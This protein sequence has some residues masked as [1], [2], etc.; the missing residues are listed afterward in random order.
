MKYPMT[1][2]C[3]AA[4][5]LAFVL[6]QGPALIAADVF[7][8]G[9]AKL[10]VYTNI[11][12]VLVDDLRN[13]PNGNYPGSPGE[14][15]YLAGL[16]SPSNYG[17]NYGARVS[18]FITPPATGSYVF[19]ISSD[20]AGEFWL[21]TDE[22]PN[23]LELLAMEPQWNGVREWGLP[24]SNTASRNPDAPENVSAPRQLTEG[25]RYYFEALVKEG[26]GGD[27]L[28]VAV[29]GANDPVPQNGSAPVSGTW[30]GVVV[31]D[32]GASVQIAQQPTGVSSA[33]NENVTFT[34]GATGTS[35]LGTNLVY[36]WFRNGDPI[37]GATSATL[38]LNRVQTADNGAAYSVLVAVPGAQATSSE[39]TLTV[40]PDV[41]PPT[42]AAAR[43]TVNFN[44][45]FVTFSEPVAQASATT[46]AN[47]TLNGGATV[48]SAT[49]VDPTTVRLVTSQL[50]EAT[51]YTL[52]VNNVTD[53]FT[54]GNP[55]AANSTVN[56]SSYTFL[57]G[58]VLN[59]FWDGP[60]SVN[61]LTNLAAFPDDPD[62]VALQ[63][64]FEYP[65]EGGGEG[66]SNYGN[67][68][69]AWWTAPES[70]NYVFFVSG[71]DTVN[72][73]LSTDSDPANV[74]LI[75]AEPTWNPARDWL[76]TL[77]PG[78][79][80][81]RPNGE[82][83]SDTFLES[84][85]PTPNVITLE[86]GQRYYLLALHGEGGG[87]DNVGATYVLQ[88]DP[89]PESGTPPIPGSELGFYYDASLST[90]EVT[91][92]PSAQTVLEGR[93]ATVSAGATG[94]W[95]WSDQ[96]FY[97]WQSAA[98]GGTAFTNIPGATGS[99]VT[100]PVLQQ[101]ESGVQ[102][103]VL[104]SVPGFNVTS[105]VAAVTVQADQVA[106]AINSVAANSS[107]ALSV[108][109][110]EPLDPAT[111]ATVAN[112]TLTPGG[113]TIT[114]ATLGGAMSNVVL[115]ATSAAIT[116]GNQYT[117][118]VSGVRDVYGNAVANLT[119]NF[120]ARIVTYAD[121]ILAD[122]PI[123]FYRFEETTG[124]STENLGTAGEAGDG[125]YM[126]GNGPDDSV[127]ADARTA[128]GP[129]PP[130]FLG[131][132]SS[133]RA[134]D[135][136][137]PDDP[138]WV[139]AQNQFLQGLGAFS[140]EYWVRPSGGR[141]E[142]PSLW[143]TRIG[144]VGQNDAIEYGFIDQNTIQIWTPGGGALDTDY[145]YPDDEWH[146]VATIASG[147]DIRNYFDGELVGTGGTAT[148]N[149]GTSAF[150]VHIGGGGV[151]DGTGN[152]FIGQID[153]VAIFDKAIPAE[154]IRA[155][156]RAGKEGGVV[157]EEQPE[158]TGITLS[159]GNVIISWTGGG[160]LESAPDATGPWAAVTGATSPHTAQ[161]TGTATFYRLRGN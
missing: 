59:K 32:T 92:Q 29:A 44:E 35:P 68:L 81:R 27:N 34:V 52:T 108:V 15:R 7:T 5:A 54:P 139:D 85:W 133:N 151:F 161:A 67:S 102:Y 36:Q 46:A 160:T 148:A 26:T 137:G 63:P 58:F 20:D 1:K 159:G 9:F 42:I 136:A 77:D 55:V 31:P 80:G 45:V 83:R 72:L 11:T 18:G 149:Y 93:T 119:A 121:I 154:R 24:V 56:F 41:T 14:T 158:F 43:A 101:A 147:T 146:H 116:A 152:F 66:G 126:S 16:E 114:S 82:N 113:L 3:A 98:A 103:R 111:A 73:Y 125:L 157:E 128:E 65:A 156:F 86:G 120:T 78:A 64:D 53:A 38:E 71:D 155:H 8:P 118:T 94:G 140:L 91:Q 132:A 25:Q 4:G 62:R 109:F 21:S 89:D 37:A 28:A 124:Q 88:G 79:P 6:V 39:A 57:P 96:P 150:N 51:P 129:R 33:A 131:F 75:A 100:T 19:Y 105:Q 50:T 17:D 130:G 30:L 2:S 153:E 74:K 76:G 110:D 60:T 84:E 70:G 12:G 104:V 143:G 122:G 69:E 22:S 10:E 48:S 106:P 142:D 61:A 47:Y 99:S 134:A 49:L 115:L 87:G 123:A 107:D 135:F 23:N 95:Q 90:L 145:P 141:L 40:T 127:P 13:D 97:Q 144:I 112:Y 117:L 138:F